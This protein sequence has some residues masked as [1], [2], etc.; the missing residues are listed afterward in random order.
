[1]RSDRRGM[2]SPELGRAKAWLKGGGLPEAL[3]VAA[4]AVDLGCGP[5]A[6]SAR[7]PQ[8]LPQ[9]GKSG[10]KL[11]FLLVCAPSRPEN[12]YSFDAV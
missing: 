2:I 10:T 6:G 1:M 3:S 4:G 9:R 7:L 8:G 12:G 5:W 11:L